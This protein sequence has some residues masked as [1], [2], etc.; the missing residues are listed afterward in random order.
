M[1]RTVLKTLTYKTIATLELAVIAWFVTGSVAS[2]THVG[3]IHLVFSTLTYAGFD[4]VFDGLWSR[5]PALV[6]G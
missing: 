1:K 4:H 3:G 2:A 5:L 6:R